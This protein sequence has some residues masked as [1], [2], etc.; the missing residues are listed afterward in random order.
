MLYGMIGIP[1]VYNSALRKFDFRS[2]WSVSPKNR[3]WSKKTEGQTAFMG[4]VYHLPEVARVRDSIVI[5]FHTT[6]LHEVTF[7]TINK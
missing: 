5:S 7:V 2:R 3:G 1:F 6:T 4:Y